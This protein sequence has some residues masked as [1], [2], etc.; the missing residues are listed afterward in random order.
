MK[1]IKG[2]KPIEKIEIKE[3]ITSNQPTT[4]NYSFAEKSPFLRLALIFLFS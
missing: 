2:K 3:D 4:F 1:I